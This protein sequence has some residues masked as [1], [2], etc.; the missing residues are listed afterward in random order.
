V[1]TKHIYYKTFMTLL[2][3]F[4]L[5]FLRC[6]HAHRLCSSADILD[7]V[8]TSTGEKVIATTIHPSP[9]ES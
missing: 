6:L 2:L 8:E 7:L 9:K 1:L 5:F 4:F 3:M